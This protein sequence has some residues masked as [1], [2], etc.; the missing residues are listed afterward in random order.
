MKG[1]GAMLSF[2]LLKNGY[3]FETFLKALKLIKPSMSLAGSREYDVLPYKTSH[4]LLSE[5]IEFHKESQSTYS[6]F[7][8]N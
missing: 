3:D 4:S 2:E 7:S 5:L 6:F 1:F 8:W